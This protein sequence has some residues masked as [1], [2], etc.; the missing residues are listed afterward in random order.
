MKTT[1]EGM[2]PVCETRASHTGLMVLNVVIRCKTPLGL[3]TCP[4]SRRAILTGCRLYSQCGHR[5]MW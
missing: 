5:F 2:L 3:G 1:H 4:R